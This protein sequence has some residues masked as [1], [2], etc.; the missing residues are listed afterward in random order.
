MLTVRRA[1][2]EDAVDIAKR[3]REA[4]LKEI[5][6]VGDSTPEESLLRGL[7]SPD[8]CYVAVDSAGIPQVIFGTAPSPDHFAGYVWMMATDEIKENWVQILRETR[9][10][11]GRIRGH[12]RLLT[13]AVHSENAVHIRWLRWAGFTI[14]REV[15]HNGHTFYEFAKII[16]PEDR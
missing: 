12:Y 3:L 4:D 10:W 13:N 7:S 15:T 16:N 9:P 6:A 8:P 5:H 14:I 11:I 2:T 1:T